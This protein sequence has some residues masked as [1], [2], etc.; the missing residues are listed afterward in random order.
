[1]SSIPNVSIPKLGV[2][3]YFGILFTTLGIYCIWIVFHYAEPGFP[4]HSYITTIV[5]YFASFALLIVVP[6][7]IAV[8]ITFRK[9]DSIDVCDYYDYYNGYLVSIYNVLFLIVLIMGSFVL[10]IEEYYNTDGYFTVLSKLLSTLYRFTFDIILMVV[11]ALIVLGILIKQKVLSTNTDTLTLV[12]IIVTNTLYETFLV[13]MLGIGLVELPRTFW[14]R[15][16]LEYSLLRQ[17]MK[18]ASAF[19]SLREAE[20]SISLAVSDVLKTKEDIMAKHY[21]QSIQN[22]ITIML[23]ECPSEFTSS[24]IGKIAANKSGQVTIHTLAALRLRL[25][26]AKDAY[27]VSQVQVDHVKSAAYFFEDIVDAHKANIQT[28][29]NHRKIKW[30]ISDKES[31]SFMYKWYIHYEPILWKVA[32]GMVAI[33]SFLSFLGVVGS[34]KGVNLNV[35]AYFEAVHHSSATSAGIVIFIFLTLGYTAINAF[36][37]LNQFRFAGC[38][39]LV[40]HRTKAESLS[41][42]VRMMAR[43]AAP[44]AFFYLAW[45]SEA[46][47]KAGE[48]Q[49]DHIYQNT[50]WYDQTLTNSTVL[51]L[52]ADGQ[53]LDCI[54]AMDSGFSNFYS[55]S[56]V[57]F[58][59]NVYGVFFPTLL[60]IIMVLHLTNLFNRILVYF[61]FD[62]YQFG[63]E[64]VTE[65]QLREGRRQLERFKQSTIRAMNRIN[66]TNKP[67]LLTNL[68]GKNKTEDIEK[69]VHHEQA[70]AVKAVAIP[71]VLLGVAEQKLES[72]FLG[73]KIGNPWSSVNLEIR[74]PGNLNIKDVNQKTTTIELHAIV[75]F[76]SSSKANKPNGYLNLELP[77]STIRL[78]FQTLKEAEMWKFRLMEWK[79]YYIDNLLVHRVNAPNRISDNHLAN[80]VNPLSKGSAINDEDSSPE[81]GPLMKGKKISNSPASKDIA[82]SS[83]ASVSL[84]EN[85]DLDEKPSSIQG[86]LM[87]KAEGQFNMG[88]QKRFYKINEFNN[89]SFYKSD[90]TVN[91]PLGVIDLK[92]IGQVT[93][94]EKKSGSE[95][96][97]RI[98]IELEDGK[99]LKLKADDKNSAQQ[100]VNAIESWRDWFL[101]Q[102][103]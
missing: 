48:K 93:M 97:W 18:A 8:S 62:H 9:S 73:L 38:M 16:N 64:I 6:F 77:D 7:D 5:G 99:K 81:D 41:F 39:V 15:G 13:I 17:Q 82:R 11:F 79:D 46:G 20:L 69:G 47:L 95:R 36:W 26:Q 3:E 98:D 32:A 70:K 58:V 53:Q 24:R 100:W 80:N 29:D 76:I 44:L 68:W 23:S 75:D 65:E 102:L 72:G 42:N 85:Q 34:Y 43:L 31:S 60:I 19:T 2:N 37:A 54:Y 94:F 89:M 61:K 67:G 59:K 40:P 66:N 78:R 83:M 51:A 27:R 21:D 92:L 87:T 4:W 45:I 71:E 1:M 10:S 84:N 55:M 57:K 86:Y 12:A 14:L 50:F 49:Y 56:A 63:A 91:S 74:Q 28:P 35:S 33:L 88:W 52:S 25:N 101:L 103:H 30:T 90:T 96:I 22:A